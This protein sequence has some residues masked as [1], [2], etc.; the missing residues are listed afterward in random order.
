MKRALTLVVV[1][2]AMTSSPSSQAQQPRTRVYNLEELRWPDIDALDRERT[3]FILPI[4]MLE[5]HGPHLPIGADTFG[6]TFEASGVARRVARA[7]PQWHVVMMP[8]MHYGEAGA[9]L[10]GGHLV[11]P[12][13]YGIRQSTLR[14]LVA[15]VGA[16][17]ARNRFKWVF[18]LTGHAAPPHSIAINEACDFVS[19]TFGVTMLHVSGIFRAD[20]T[21]QANGRTAALRHYSPSELS[22]FGLDV[23]AGVSET[24]GMLALRPDLV[25]GGYK[26]LPAQTGHT[27]EELQ[28]LARAPGWQGYL[29]SP[30]KATA[31]YGRAVEQWWIDGMTEVVLRALKGQNLFDEPRAP[32]VLDPS[33]ASVVRHA[34]EDEEALDAKLQE[35]LVRRRQSR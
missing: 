29:S 27:R 4:G 15:D 8:T 7:F 17:V 10:L 16:Q 3:M 2:C 14:A 24:S 34:L 9:N 31:G 30:A 25:H 28:A 22:S 6:V 21:M 19:E 13:T 23:H 32:G 26:K 11:H 35:W 33:V 5:E 12:G 18:V 20:E 1:L